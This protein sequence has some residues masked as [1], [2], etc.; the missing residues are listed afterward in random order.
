MVTRPKKKSVLRGWKGKH[1][2][3][4]M[5]AFQAKA[6]CS[7]FLCSL[8][9]LSARQPITNMPWY[10][11]WQV[12]QIYVRFRCLKSMLCAMRP[13]RKSSRNDSEATLGYY[14][15]NMYINPHQ[16]PCTIT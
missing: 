4:T 14:L 13:S 9:V 8:I 6:L 7:G 16:K 1:F 10:N 15:T 11:A 3:A 2:P 12:P 5:A